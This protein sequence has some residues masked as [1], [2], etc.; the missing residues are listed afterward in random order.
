MSDDIRYLITKI[1]ATLTEQKS[2]DSVYAATGS[3]KVGIETQPIS[4]NIVVYDNSY[5]LLIKSAELISVIIP[6]GSKK[7]RKAAPEKVIK[8]FIYYMN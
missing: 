4:V 6:F 2:K 5:W 7:E 8:T 1:P 3:I